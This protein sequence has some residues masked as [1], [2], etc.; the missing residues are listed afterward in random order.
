MRTAT[1]RSQP[2]ANDGTFGHLVLDDGST[3]MTGEL[4]W[5]NNDHGTSCIP[6]GTYTLHWINSQKHGWCYQ[7]M[8]VPFRDMIEIHS[9]NFMGDT[10]FGKASQLLGCIAL[11]DSIGE[12][13]PSPTKEPQM[14]VLH[15]KDA[16]K[17]FD[18]NLQG[19][20]C[21]LLIQRAK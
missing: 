1:L 21:L 11:G 8:N 16:I 19:E 9:A 17:R 7:V 2:S 4:P 12:L 3:F 6:E 20:D 13:S 5:K 15:S 18:D 10:T 14:A